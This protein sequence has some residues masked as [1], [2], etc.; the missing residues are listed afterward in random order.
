VSIVQRATNILTR[1]KEEWPRIDAEPATAGGLLMG[2]ALPLALLPVLGTIIGGLLFR[3]QFAAMPGLGGAFWSFIIASALIGLVLGLAVLYVMSLIADALAPNFG[4]VRNPVGALKM[5]VYA[6][7]ATWV[8][9]FLSFIPVVG[10]LIGILGFIYAAYLI[11]LGSTAVMKVPSTSAGG[12]TAVVIVIW[13][14][15]SLVVAFIVGLIVAAVVLGGTVA[16][17]G[18]ML[19]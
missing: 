19:R 2:Y 7:T 13:I 6:G 12:Y 4:G 5:L 11:Y 9:G 15:L 16:S 10:W 1:P 8:A 18:Y 14:V 17:G 3:D